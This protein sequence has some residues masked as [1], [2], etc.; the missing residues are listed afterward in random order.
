M[1]TSA[2]F[3]IYDSRFT[4]WKKSSV[5]H[6]KSYIVN[7]K[8]RSGIAL[9]ITLIMLAVTLV[10]AVAF[11]AIA[12]RERNA[13]TTATDTAA[14]R[15]ADDAALAAAQA[16]IAANLLATANPYNYNLLVSTNYTTAGGIIPNTATLD[17][18]SY[19]DTNGDLLTGDY[20]AQ[21]IA[22][23]YLLPRAPVFVANPKTG[24]NDFRFYLDLN[25]NGQFDPNGVVSNLE[26]QSGNLVTNGTV[27]V[28]G[29]PE[30]IGILEHPDQPHSANNPFVARY[31]FLAQPAG[32]SL[33]L[34]YIHNQVFDENSASTT[35]YPN[36]SDAFFRNQSV[37]SWEL[38]LAAFL[39]DLNTNQW[40]QV[41]GS[42]ANGNTAFYYYQY[43]GGDNRGV[44]FYDAQALLAWRYANNYSSLSK[45]NQI[46]INTPFNAANIFPYDNIDEYSDGPLQITT[47]NINEGLG[48]HTADGDWHSDTMPWAGS[49]NTNRFFAVVSDLFDPTKSSANFTSRLT[50]TGTNVDTYDRYTYYRMLDELGT[51]STTDDSRMNLNYRNITN[52][53]VVPGME[54]N[55]SPWGA[56]DFFTNAA[57]RMLRYYTANWVA[58]NYT[59]YTN[60]FGMS[61]TNAFGVTNIPVYINGQFVYTPAVNRILQLA[62]NMYDATTNQTVGGAVR[63][64]PSVFRPVF[65][66]IQDGVNQDVFIIGYTRV[67]NVNTTDINTNPANPLYPPFSLPDIASGMATGVPNYINIYGVPWIIGAK[68]GYPNFN[69]FAMKNTLSVTRRLQFTRTTNNATVQMTGTNQMYTMGLNSSIGIEF[70]NSYISNYTGTIWVGMNENASLSITND[71]PGF[72]VHPGTPVPNYFYTNVVYAVSNW[73]GSGTGLVSGNVDT[74]SF[75]VANLVGPTMPI[76][77]YRS[78]SAT[79]ANLGGLGFV[80]PCFMNTNFFGNLSP[81]SIYETGS[82]NG[83]HFPQFG[84]VLTNRLRVFMLA[85]DNGATNVIDYASFAGPDG[86]FNVNSKLA[87]PDAGGSI[88]R[89]SSGGVWSTNYKPGNLAPNG[90]TWGILNQI[91]AGTSGDIPGPDGGGTWKADPEANMLGTTAISQAANFAAFFKAG[92]NLPLTVQAPYT[93]TRNIVQYFTWQASDPLVHYLASDISGPPPVVDTTTFP[94]LGVNPYNSGQTILPLT[95]LNLGKVNYRYMPWS[96]NQCFPP[97]ELVTLD[98]NRF[99]LSERDPGVLQP[100]NWD[101]PNY[102][103]PTIGWL[104]RVH[105]GTPWQTVYLKASDFLANNNYPAWQAWTGDTNVFDATNAAPVQDARLFDLFSTTPNGNATHG[106]L[107]VNQTHLAAWSA[108]FGGLVALTNV[109]TSPNSITAPMV[110]SLAI[111]PAGPDTVNSALALLLNGT[112]GINAT[113]GATTNADGVTGAFEHVGDILRTPALTEQSPFLNWNNTAQQQYGISDELYEWLPQQTLGLLRL[114]SAPRYVVYCYGQALR[115][116]PNSVVT[117]SGQYFGLV[118]NYQITA[119]TAARAVIRVDKNVTATGTNYS[120]VIESYVPL[121]PQ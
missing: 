16:Q 71:D 2:K 82:A 79:A 18:I 51:D 24:S 111:P 8:S 83:F 105:R 90:A 29:D 55:C 60:T 39:T 88:Q 17:Y 80:A 81:L 52:G 40:G 62:A 119:E 69:E 5:G 84:V 33:D 54:T 87:D 99:T 107:S 37:G 73:T 101:F 57:D 19:Y 116:A 74:N 68:K 113:R 36:N 43:L 108:V 117:A 45:A 11:L 115:P 41:I 104:G 1:K 121:P 15:L 93:P 98:T 75:L 97:S 72:N 46:F 48:I 103:F 77:V 114:S 109:T 110:N 38:N 30:W 91:T 22:N 63:D 4:I 100:E 76:S 120:S 12:R 58:A 94:Q 10:M 13:S 31:A 56:L 96:G 47:A 42:P 65:T 3:T 32:N 102:K 14:A 112:Q 92:F 27:M 50:A 6:R 9:V 61:V 95:S 59:A 20:L 106:T 66:R 118:T 34:N 85:V 35:V 25:R 53:V 49:D 86:S 89:F 28:Q 44:A 7:H 67:A 78:P 26:F 64:Y 70:W 21:S 23:L